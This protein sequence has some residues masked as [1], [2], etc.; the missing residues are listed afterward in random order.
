MAFSLSKSGRLTLLL[1]TGHGNPY[2]H[3]NLVV[4]DVVCEGRSPVARA[5]MR[6][7]L[8]ML[9]EASVEPIHFMEKWPSRHTSPDLSSSRPLPDCPGRP[10]RLL[11]TDA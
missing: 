10:Q 6:S 1:D 11:I 4:G 9:A 8:P 5:P 3:E 7:R 2:P